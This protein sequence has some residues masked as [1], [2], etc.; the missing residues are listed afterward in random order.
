MTWKNSHH[1]VLSGKKDY[2]TE[3][4]HYR[5]FVNICESTSKEMSFRE[6][7]SKA[8]VIWVLKFFQ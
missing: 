2:K 4:T 5:I 1:T 6:Y 7:I 8:T 3:Y